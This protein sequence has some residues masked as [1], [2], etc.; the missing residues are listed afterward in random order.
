LK[1]ASRVRQ[2]H[3]ARRVIPKP[4]RKLLDGKPRFTGSLGT[5]QPHRS[6]P[7]E[8]A[9]VAEWKRQ[10]NHQERRGGPTR[11][12]PAQGSSTWTW[13]PPRPLEQ[14]DGSSEARRRMTPLSR[15]RESPVNSPKTWNSDGPKFSV[16][17]LP[18]PKRRHGTN[19]DVDN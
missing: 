16:L 17:W 5:D 12:K 14:V 8:A 9:V 2:D 18:L 11:S 15:R 4:L 6:E 10:I 1:A 7:P 13:P 3:M 19:G